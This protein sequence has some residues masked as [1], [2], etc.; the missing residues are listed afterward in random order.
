VEPLDSAL[1]P[2]LSAYQ[3]LKKGVVELEQL[4]FDTGVFGV[5]GVGFEFI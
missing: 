1:L 4:V 2:I 3:Q 5:F